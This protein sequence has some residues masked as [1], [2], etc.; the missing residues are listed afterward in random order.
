MIKGR[1]SKPGWREKKK[2]GGGAVEIIGAVDG[3][4][5]DDI[6]VVITLTLAIIY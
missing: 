5:A 4:A 6:Y 2:V 1:E 3:A